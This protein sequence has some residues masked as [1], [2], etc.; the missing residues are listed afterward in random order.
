MVNIEF[1]KLQ[2]VVE[3]KQGDLILLTNGQEAEFVRLKQKKFIGTIDGIAYDIP[4]NMFDKLLKH[5]PKKDTDAYKTLEKGELFYINQSGK[6]LLFIF[7]SFTQSS[8]PNII[9]VN[10]ISH[11]KVKIDHRL[12]VGKVSE[13][14]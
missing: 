3:L 1:S 14:R 11:G 7:D 2:K 10:P 6:A 9:G 8:M 13:I 12:Y 5:A 4:V